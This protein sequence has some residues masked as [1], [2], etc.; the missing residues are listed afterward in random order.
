MGNGKK[1]FGKQH[2]PWAIHVFGRPYNMYLCW[3]LAFFSFYYPEQLDTLFFFLSQLIFTSIFLCYIHAVCY[4]GGQV[5]RSFFQP[6]NCLM[7]FHCAF[8][9]LFPPSHDFML[10]MTSVSK[11]CLA[12]WDF[13]LYLITFVIFLVYF[14]HI[15]VIKA[16]IQLFCRNFPLDIHSWE[17]F[18]PW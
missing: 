9:F 14:K 12:P 1:A 3:D 17:I 16:S 10:T 2:Q 5:R 4:V 13:Y 11:A 18:V 15:M 7:S 8:L 6:W